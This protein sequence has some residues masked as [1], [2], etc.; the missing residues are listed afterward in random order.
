MRGDD[1]SS[2]DRL[3]FSLLMNTLFGHWGHA[4][5]A[6]NFDVVNT[7]QITGVLSHPGGANHWRRAVAN[8][9]ISLPPEFIEFVNDVLEEVESGS[10]PKSENK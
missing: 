6:E 3:R 7:S 2:S 10:R 4:F 1:L 9:T 5:D 8:K